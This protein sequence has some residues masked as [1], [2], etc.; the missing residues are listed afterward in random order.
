MAIV[1]L[2]CL[3]FVPNNFVRLYRD[4]C[5]Y[6]PVFKK[7]YKKLVK[8]CVAIVIL[9]LEENTQHFGILCFIISRKVKMQLKVQKRFVPC[10]EKVLLTYQTCQSGFQSFVG[11]ISPP[12][13]KIIIIYIFKKKKI[14]IWN[15]FPV[16]RGVNWKG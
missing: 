11:E 10:L 16:G 14:N 15:F 2:I 6:Q 3:N 8:F 4:S 5:H 12:L 13:P 7:T 1:A 9:R